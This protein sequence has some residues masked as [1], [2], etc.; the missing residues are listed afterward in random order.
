MISVSNLK[1][2]LGDEL[3]DV[4]LQNVLVE[5]N[6][7]HNRGITYSDFLGLWNTDADETMQNA[8]IDVGTRRVS[9]ASAVVST[10]SSFS[11]FGS[12]DNFED[13]DRFPVDMTTGAGEL[14]TG[15]YFFKE[16][17]EISVRKIEV[18]YGDV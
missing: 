10:I 12:D 9:P 6:G 16:R 17:K 7:N 15:T 13:S 11:S 2:F 8:K 5:A 18:L 4:Y 3:P 1:E 14:K